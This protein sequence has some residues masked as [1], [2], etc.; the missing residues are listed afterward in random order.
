[1]KQEPM[2]LKTNDQVNRDAA[3]VVPTSETTN[4]GSGSTHGSP[5]ATTDVTIALTG[6]AASG[7]S[8]VAELVYDFLK[9]QG[10]NCELRD[11]DHPDRQADLEKRVDAV[12]RKGTK[13]VV[14]AANRAPE[15]SAQ[16]SGSSR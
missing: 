11:H 4:G 12:K 8:T 2:G 6:K 3:S 9:S 14:L 10:I 16:T 13:F 15:K 5:S 1:M 7:K